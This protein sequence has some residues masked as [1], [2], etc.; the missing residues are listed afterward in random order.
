MVELEALER[1]DC[2][3]LKED[4]SGSVVDST[5]IERGLNQ[6]ASKSAQL[7]R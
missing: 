2:K 7:L 6:P 1:G 4:G 5:E 3:R